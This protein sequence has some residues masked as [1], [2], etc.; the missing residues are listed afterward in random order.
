MTSRRQVL[1]SVAAVAALGA[2]W[3]RAQGQKRY[4]PGVSDSEIMFGSTQPLSGAAAAYSGAMKVADAY[5]KLLNTQG[6]INGRKLKFVMLDDGY[7]P[8]RTVDQTRR[9]VEQDGVAFLL[10]P[11]GTATALSVRQYLNERKVPQLFIGSA[12]ATWSEDIDKF[13]WSLGFAP[14]YPDEGRSVGQHIVATRPQAKVA[15][16]FQNDDAGKD[17]GKGARA[18]LGKLLIAEQSYEFSD[19]TVD[20][21]VISLQA[22][23]ADTLVALAAPRVAAQAIRKAYDSGWKPQIY[24]VSVSTS[25]PNVLAAA[26][27]DKAKGMISAAYLKDPGDPTWTNDK[28]M[29]EFIAFM[30]THTPSIP[31]DNLAVEGYCKAVVLA[32]V[33]R[34]CGNDL[35]RE[36]IVQQTKQLDME[37]PLML[38]GIKV[39][40]SE[41]ERHPVRGFRMQ[42]FDGASWKVLLT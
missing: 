15:Y 14:L 7:V 24:M 19:P 36:N 32:Q 40:T 38:P 8:P 21:Q 3:A 35:S 10:S 11:V 23:G 25:V 29:Q 31:K 26:G 37:I 39:K 12:G 2:P 6:G 33:L 4:A 9:L 27:L 41:K 1:Q 22:S 17:Y 28:P 34:Q 30:N 42:Q 13:P 20:S 16:L 5:F 18:A